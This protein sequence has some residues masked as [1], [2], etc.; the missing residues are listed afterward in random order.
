MS[1][2]YLTLFSSRACKM[3]RGSWFLWVSLSHHHSLWHVI[4]SLNLKP[5]QGKYFLHVVILWEFI[6]CPLKKADM[7]T[8]LV[9]VWSW[10]HNKAYWVICTFS[11]EAEERWEKVIFFCFCLCSTLQQPLSLF[12]YCISTEYGGEIK[13]YNETCLYIC[14]Y[15]ILTCM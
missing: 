8:K 7:G 11:T 14:K 12:S 1:S 9:S 4:R 5:K 13:Y 2:L 10:S 6:F 3:F 15:V